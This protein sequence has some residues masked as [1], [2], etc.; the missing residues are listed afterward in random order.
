MRANYP[1]AGFCPVCALATEPENVSVAKL[2]D[3]LFQYTCNATWRHPNK[4]PLTRKKESEVAP[5]H[6]GRASW[7]N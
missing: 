4:P 3:G 1:A 6:L 5:Y 2:A 7:V